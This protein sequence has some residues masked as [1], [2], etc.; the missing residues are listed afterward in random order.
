MAT[1]QGGLIGTGMVP[2]G[3]LGTELSAVTRRA[4]IPELIIQIYQASPVLYMLMR[5]AQRAAGG[6]GNITVPVQGNAVTAPGYIDYGGSFP[7]PQDQTGIFDAAAN[8]SVAAVPIPFFGIESLVQATE[9]IIPR[10]KVKMGDAKQ[11]MVQLWSNSLFAVT[12]ATSLSLQPFAAAYDDGVNNAAYAN[13]ANINRLI[14]TFWKSTVYTS[15]GAV[16][17]TSKFIFYLLA[18]TSKAGGERPDLVIMSLAD[19]TT[20]M[21]NFMTIEQFNTGPGTRYGK[22][23]PVNA[24]FSCLMLGDTPIVADLYCPVGTAYFINTKYFALYMSED[25]PFVFSG[26]YSAIPNNQIANVGVLIVAAQTLCTKPVS[27][28]Q[29][30]GIT[31]GASF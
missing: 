25:A 14:Q 29:V 5:G 10:L 22:N 6:V 24:G 18:A 17:T 2:G 13:Y 19:W 11:Q 28:V 1:G 30:T 20:L 16:L 7:Q 9:T 31:G 27:G 4:F 26:F 21:Q 12:A 3:N 23:D 8:L 15:A